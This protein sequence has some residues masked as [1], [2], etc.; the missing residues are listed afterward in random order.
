VA[1]GLVGGWYG[2]TAAS[3]IRGALGGGLT[4]A[5]V[6][7]ALSRVL[8]P[9]MYRLQVAA[10]TSDPDFSMKFLLSHCLLHAGLGAGMGIAAGTALGWGLGDKASL[11]RA[12]AGG[13]LG[14]LA[15]V[16]LFETINSLAFPFMK[17]EAPLPEESLARLAMYLCV[18]GGAALLA[19]L[20]A[21]ARRRQSTATSLAS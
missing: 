2:G 21:A 8:V 3:R 6:G 20:A 1:L 13:L 18:A 11:G 12:L 4:A 17:A 10:L 5:F 16:F 14:A 19:G 15:G 7:A 9:V